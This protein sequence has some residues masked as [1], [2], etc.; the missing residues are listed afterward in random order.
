[1]KIKVKPATSEI[2]FG[3]GYLACCIIVIVV[4]TTQ[5]IVATKE[6]VVLACCN[7]ILVVVGVFDIINI[8]PLV[9]VPLPAVDTNKMALSIVFDRVVK[10]GAVKVVALLGVD[11]SYLT[12]S[13]VGVGIG[14]VIVVGSITG[15]AVVMF[16]LRL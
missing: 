5:F 12:L 9:L 2:E 14:L 6:V 10:H 15:K 13:V 8:L 7:E 4:G 1:M 11:A 3:E 16:G